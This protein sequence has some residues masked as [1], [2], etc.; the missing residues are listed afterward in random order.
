MQRLLIT[1]ISIFI[2]A[3]CSDGGK[4]GTANKKEIFIKDDYRTTKNGELLID[5]RD[6]QHAQKPIATSRVG[7]QDTPKPI[8]DNS[9]ISTMIDGF[10]NKTE[11][12]IF[13]NHPLLQRIVV[14][15][16]AGGRKKVFVY[17]NNGDVNGL[18]TNIINKA[19]TASANEL[20]NSAGISNKRDSQNEPFFLT[21]LQAKSEETLLPLPSYQFPVIA[22]ITEQ[23]QPEESAPVSRQIP[24]STAQ[25]QPKEKNYQAEI[26]RILLQNNKR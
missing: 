8:A 16:F 6:F 13:V 23:N 11:T 7:S 4:S 15:T 21:I 12:R 22:N 9:Q 20:A 10:G 17:G 1:I 25:K 18:P 5:D 26:N 3:S 19:M 24:M 14:R 2:A